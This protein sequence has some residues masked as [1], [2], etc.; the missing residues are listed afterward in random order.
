MV[1]FSIIRKFQNSRRGPS[2]RER[3]TAAPLFLARLL[4]PRSPI[5]ATAELLYLLGSAKITLCVY[6]KKESLTLSNVSQTKRIDDV[7]CIDCRTN[8]D[9]DSQ[10]IQIQ[11][12][13]VMCRLVQAANADDVLFSSQS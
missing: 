3:G 11:N 4:W 10:Q 13:F 8:Y 7:L 9:V 12:Q 2:S 6:N 5:S 1:N